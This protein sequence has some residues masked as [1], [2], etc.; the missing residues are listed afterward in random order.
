MV[1]APGLVVTARTV[2][3][4]RAG[5]LAANILSHSADPDIVT[6]W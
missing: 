5:G 4:P 6:M 2:L 1:Q 3:A